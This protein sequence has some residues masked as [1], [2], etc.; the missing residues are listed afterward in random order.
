VK[1]TKLMD[2]L[3]VQKSKQIWQLSAMLGLSVRNTK[4]AT[5]SIEGL[6]K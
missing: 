3:A 1:L 6:D 4:R 5:L 2:M